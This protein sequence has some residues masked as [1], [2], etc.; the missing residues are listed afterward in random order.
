MKPTQTA[1][2]CPS[3]ITADS[4]RFGSNP[5]QKPRMDASVFVLRNHFTDDPHWQ[6]LADKL[7]NYTLPEYGVSCTIERMIL[8][9]ERMEIS[10]RQYLNAT[11][12]ENLHEYI[13]LNPTFPLRAFVGELLEL[14]EGA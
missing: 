9:L 7:T 14:K 4:A 13:E 5:D 10:P 12:L 8:W 11:A 1:E 6:E 3:P 2:D